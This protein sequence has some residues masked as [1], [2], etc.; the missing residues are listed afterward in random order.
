VLVG[1]N[2]MVKYWRAARRET[3]EMLGTQFSFNLGQ[4]NDLT[5]WNGSIPDQ[6][7]SI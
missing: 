6:C 3:S 1:D 5:G 7:H 2:G 4:P